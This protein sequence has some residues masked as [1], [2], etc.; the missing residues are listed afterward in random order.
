MYH[1]G[2]GTGGQLLLPATR[3]ALSFTPTINRRPH[4]IGHDLT[5]LT[6]YL[7]AILPG[8]TTVG[9]TGYEAEDIGF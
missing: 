9:L 2:A 8:L 6:W 5:D 1:P 4:P 7:T 3:D